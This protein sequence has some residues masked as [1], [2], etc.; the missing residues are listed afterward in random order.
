MRLT[1]VGRLAY[2]ALALLNLWMLLRLIPGREWIGIVIYAVL[3]GIL[4]WP[5]IS[6]RD[7][8]AGSRRAPPWLAVPEAPG[9][10][11]PPRDEVQARG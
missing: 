4:G 11:V 7:V 9:D 2:A 6:G 8:L 5:A 1:R 10:R 3:T